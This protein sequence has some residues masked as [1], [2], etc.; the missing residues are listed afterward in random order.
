MI[1]IQI[2]IKQTSPTNISMQARGSHVEGELATEGETQTADKIIVGLNELFRSIGQYT[3]TRPA[4]IISKEVPPPEKPEGE[5]PPS[6]EK[7]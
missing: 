2:E 7:S 6:N 1:V 5:R 3:Q 4:T